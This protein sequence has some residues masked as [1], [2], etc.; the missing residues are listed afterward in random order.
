MAPPTMTMR[1]PAAMAS[2]AV[3]ELIPRQRRRDAHR[4]ANLAQNGSRVRC[5]HL[6]VDAVWTPRKSAPSASSWRARSTWLET[7]IR[8]MDTLAPYCFA[9]LDTFVQRESE[10]TAST[11]TMEAPL[12]RYLHL[13][14]AGVHGFHVGH[15]RQIGES[16]MQLAPAS[17]PRS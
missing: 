1:A 15:D 7:S 12:G 17:N 11:A 3:S 13:R 8:S 6:H 2:A 4:P 14:A 9:R 10:A 16:A 5:A